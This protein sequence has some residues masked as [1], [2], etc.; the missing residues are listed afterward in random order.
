MELLWPVWQW[1]VIVPLRSR[2]LDLIEQAVLGLLVVRDRDS[3]E[4]ADALAL[5]EGVVDLVL[6]RL[7]EDGLL[8]AEGVTCLLYTSPSPRD[9]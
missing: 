1:Q 4:L 6:E 2:G 8:A 7:R 3:A 9:S 5:D